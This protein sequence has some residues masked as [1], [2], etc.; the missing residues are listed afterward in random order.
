MKNQLFQVNM[1]SGEMFSVNMPSIV[2]VAQR[3]PEAEQIKQIDHKILQRRVNKLNADLRSVCYL[4]LSE[5]DDFFQR[6][7]TENGFGYPVDDIFMMGRS[8]DGAIRHVDIG[9]A[10]LTATWH[11][12]EVSGKFEIVAYAN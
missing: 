5:I 2:Q 12:M 11:K 7:L 4:D 6:A 10:Y 3:Y 8:Q 1:H 9:G